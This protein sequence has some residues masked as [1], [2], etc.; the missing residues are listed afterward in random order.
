MLSITLAFNHR[1][2]KKTI[3]GDKYNSTIEG[4]ERS[5][6]CIDGVEVEMGG[7]FIQNEELRCT[8]D[9]SS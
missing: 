9:N 3:V 6:K 5:C 8:P 1:S 7:D 4:R 2:D